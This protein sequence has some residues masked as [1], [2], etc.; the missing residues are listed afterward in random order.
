MFNIKNLINAKFKCH[1]KSNVCK[2]GVLNI[3]NYNSLLNNYAIEC[4]LVDFIFQGRTN[5]LFCSMFQ[6]AVT[7]KFYCL[8]VLYECTKNVEIYG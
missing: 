4:L 2:S 7:E 6:P 1:H 8:S 3:R 5:N